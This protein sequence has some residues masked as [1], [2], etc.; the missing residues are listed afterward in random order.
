MRR[1]MRTAASFFFFLRRRLG[2]YPGASCVGRGSPKMPPA[3]QRRRCSYRRF[4]RILCV[5]GLSLGSRAVWAIVLHF[6]RRH[7]RGTLCYGLYA[8]APL[9]FRSPFVEVHD[10]SHQLWSSTELKRP[11]DCLWG[12]GPVRTYHV[13]LGQLRCNSFQFKRRNLGLFLSIG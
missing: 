10:L 2:R 4:E 12:V 3:E 13:K 11:K 5:L 8:W 9:V 7:R 1:R 6:S